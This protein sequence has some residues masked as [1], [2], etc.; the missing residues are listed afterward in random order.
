MF[1]PACIS[2]YMRLPACAC[3]C[4]GRPETAW[5]GTPRAE[6][7]CHCVEAHVWR[8]VTHGHGHRLWGTQRL[9]A[10]Q[11]HCRAGA[12]RPEPPDV[13]RGHLTDSSEELQDLPDT[14]RPC[15]GL[16]AVL[17]SAQRGHEDPPAQACLPYSELCVCS[18]HLVFQDRVL[19]RDLNLGL[20]CHVI[21]RQIWSGPASGA[22]AS[23]SGMSEEHPRSTPQGLVW[24]P[25]RTVRVASS[26]L[27]VEAP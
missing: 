2:T 18:N 5:Q 22:Q 27:D 20:R 17:W 12:G 4:T 26:I 10:E 8:L 14:H 6:L 7:D 13:A 23:T 9:V 1:K 19:D 24:F 16:R 11:R 3:V 21:S 15:R 25:T